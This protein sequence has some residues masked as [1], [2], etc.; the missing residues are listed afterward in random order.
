MYYPK[1]MT[2]ELVSQLYS[3]EA[4]V[5]RAAIYRVLFDR[6][7][8]ML[9]EL[10]KAASFEEDETIAVFMVQ[11]GLTLEAFPRD[12]SVERRIIEF[13]QREDGAG[14]LSVA[15]WKYLMNS[16]SSKMLI[17]ALGGM[18]EAIPPDAQEF[19]EACLNHPDPDIRAMACEKAIKSGRPTHLA[20]VLNLITDPDPMVAETAFTV[21]RD[22]PVNELAIILD[23]ALGSPDEWVLQNVAPFLPLI[24][25]SGLRPVISKVQYHKHPLVS[26]KAREALKALDS[27]PYVVKRKRVD[28]S[29]IELSIDG[30]ADDLVEPVACAEDAA[31]VEKQLSFKEQMELKRLQKMEEERR[32]KAEE[33][34]LAAELAKVQPEDLADF[35][36]QLA[37]FDTIASGADDQINFADDVP[38]EDEFTR[39]TSFEDQAALLDCVADDGT[40]IEFD[41]SEGFADDIPATIAD[42]AITFESEAELEMDFQ[43]ESAA[44][45]VPAFAPADNNFD[46]IVPQA[47]ETDYAPPD[48]NNIDQ[49][50][51]SSWEE[52][53]EPASVINGSVA[54]Q[55]IESGF[56]P[57]SPGEEKKSEPIAEQPA[58]K[59]K[60]SSNSTISQTPPPAL[61][62]T[63][64]KDAVPAQSQSQTPAKAAVPGQTQ[65]PVQVPVSTQAKAETPANAATSTQ[66]L[67]PAQAKAQPPAGAA[68]P[69]KTQSPAPAKAAEPAPASTSIKNAGSTA[70][71]LPATV[72]APVLSPAPA[73]KP[74]AAAPVLATEN[75]GIIAASDIAESELLIDL[76]AELP[77]TEVVSFDPDSIDF[78]AAQNEDSAVAKT[79]SEVSAEEIAADDDDIEFQVF[80]E[81]TGVK[82]S[83]TTQSDVSFPARVA[84]DN[85]AED[86][87]IGEEDIQ[88][89]VVDVNSPVKA[90]AQKNEP[91]ATP[92]KSK[93]ANRSA[94]TNKPAPTAMAR[95][96]VTAALP[97]A[98][99]EIVSRYPSF[100]SDPFLQLFQTTRH[101]IQLKTIGLVVDNLIAF[102]NLCYLQSCL[103]F[104]PESEVLSKS[105]KE[106]IKG[107]LVGPTAL[108]CLHNFALA[109]KKTRSNPVFFT[110]SLAAILSESSDANPLMMMRELKEFLRNPVMPLEESMPQAIEGL[111]EILR[112]VKS[113]L[114]NSLVMKAP[115]GAKEPFADLSGPEARVL[116]AEKRPG[117]DLPVGE[118]ILLSRDGTEALGL[119]PYFK[120]ARK[121]IIFARPDDKEIAVLLERLEIPQDRV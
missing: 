49:L 110:F 116:A 20:Y 99:R 56:V 75:N 61:A 93:P 12:F 85:E 5:K 53:E 67:V 71:S 91:A 31:P 40:V 9:P 118:I 109:M 8:D 7:H 83:S 4:E 32:R 48:D 59:Q 29:G 6:R 16:G 22:M 45:S 107:H 66:N 89:S 73:T 70:A 69:A 19:I 51:A 81:N 87:G 52:M 46:Q 30:E 38:A 44:D 84:H 76:E 98:A 120:Y 23:Y 39:N 101:D 28:E 82:V 50:S 77:P 35:A 14:H 11:V 105:I 1:A 57:S 121:K 65:T 108:R 96:V 24:I 60:H 72:A 33:E 79:I 27:I 17:A 42:V 95:P 74:A 2:K 15:M 113:I 58:E 115:Q 25:N 34:E 104:A 112:G 86:M 94:V 37:E 13:L 102:L 36:N 43:S 97:T 114:N 80:D 100:I 62:K 10:K 90:S 47:V 3:S 63:T 54:R 119:F 106:C 92:D 117:L 103:F 111:T 41:E 78:S 64:A 18:G 55:S 88:V 26:K 68:S 21:V